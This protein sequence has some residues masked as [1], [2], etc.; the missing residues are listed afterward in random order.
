MCSSDLVYINDQRR[1]EAPLTLYLA[2]GEYK[3]EFRSPD[4]TVAQRI[5]IGSFG[6][7][8]YRFDPGRSSISKLFQ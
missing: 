5:E 8:E 3:L 2:P 7:N 4:R 1:G 6:A